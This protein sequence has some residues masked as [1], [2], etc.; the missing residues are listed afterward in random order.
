MQHAPR[1]TTLESGVEWRT[2]AL[3]VVIHGSWV[4]LVLTHRHV[5]FWLTMGALAVV[6]AWHGSLQHEATHGH[7]SRH[8]ILNHILVGL[9]LGLWLP[10]GVSK[11]S[12]LAHHEAADREAS[13][14][15]EDGGAQ[16][17]L[18]NSPSIAT[19]SPS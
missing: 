7:P 18:A 14:A 5:P 16:R 12:N 10:Y 15:S 3:A 8:P 2:V 4:T 9:P 6:V 19:R 1:A 13:R 17:W 11:R